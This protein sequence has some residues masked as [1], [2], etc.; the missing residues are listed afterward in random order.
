MRFIKSNSDDATLKELGNRIVQ[1]RLNSN[2]TQEI[3][4]AEAGVSKRT[5]HRIEHGHSTQTSNLI[6]I[7]RAL[8]LLENL[9]VLIPE[10]AISPIQQAKMQGKKRKRAS[11]KS[12]KPEQKVPWSW[13]N[14]EGDQE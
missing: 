12:D 9:E 1:Y 7:L 8:R 14:D 5:I 3:L 2:W 6:R 11:S 4:A 10:P 13:N